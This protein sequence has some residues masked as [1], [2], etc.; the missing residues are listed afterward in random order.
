MYKGVGLIRL[1]AAMKKI[2]IVMFLTVMALT[3]TLAA[4]AQSTSVKGKCTDMQG[5]PIVGGVVQ[6][7]NLDSGRQMKIKTDKRGEYLSLGVAPGIYKVTLFGPDGKQL[8]FFGKVQVQ[9]DA[10]KNVYDFDLKKEAARGPNGVVDEEARKKTEAAMKENAKIGN[11][12]NMLKQAADFRT[13]GQCDQAV[14]LMAQAAQIDATKHQIWNSLAESDACA[15]KYPE[16]IEAY[17]KA[18]A[19]NPTSGGYYNNMAGA[20]VKNNQVDDA[21]A[22]YA[23]AGE[24]EPAN[25]GMYYF[26]EGAVLYNKGK[27]DEASKAFDKVLTI[28]P[29]KADAYYY[30]GASMLGKATLGK[31]GKMEAPAGTAEAFNKYLELQPTGPHAEEAKAMLSA[32]GAKVETTYGAGRKKGK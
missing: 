15:K 11:L 18:I 13:A 8:F 20:M 3:F 2:A 32:I 1:E 26:N 24:V 19:L 17:K 31:D 9:L 27:M 5:N 12:N 29:T 7:D 23:K 16:A 14:E 4:A 30:K 21:I 6:Y 22:A 10:D 28:D 25:A